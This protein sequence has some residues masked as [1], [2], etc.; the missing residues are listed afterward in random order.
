MILTKD[1]IGKT[2]QINPNG[3]N[4]LFGIIIDW[5]DSGV[6]FKIKDYE[7]EKWNKDLYVKDSIH[8]ISFSSGLTFRII[9]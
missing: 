7:G 4:K 6:F 2:V 8:F 9:E 1:L 5:F 3:S